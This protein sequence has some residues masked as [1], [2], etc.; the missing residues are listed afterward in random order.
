MT[1]KSRGRRMR[2][3]DYMIDDV[4]RLL[5][6]C[7]HASRV[8]GGSEFSEMDDRESRSRYIDLR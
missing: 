7:L 6:V 2:S 3:I 1:A 8:R 5:V 4:A